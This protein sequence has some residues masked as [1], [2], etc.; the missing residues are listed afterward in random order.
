MYR[1]QPLGLSQVV[2]HIKYNI[3]INIILF[4]IKIFNF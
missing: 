2:L 3:N 4:D 1:H